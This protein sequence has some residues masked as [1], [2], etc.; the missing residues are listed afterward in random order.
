M[1]KR[2]NEFVSKTDIFTNYFS[3]RKKTS[4]FN[5]RSHEEFNYYEFMSMKLNFIQRRKKNKSLKN[6]Q[7][8]NRNS[9]KCY[10]CDK[11]NHFAKNCRSKRL[12]LQR[13]INATLKVVFETDK[14]WKKVV[15]SKYT[16]TSKDNSNDDYYLIDESKKLQQ[17]LN[18]IASNKI[19]V[20]TKE[21]NFNIKQIVKKRSRT[22]YSSAIYSKKIT[23]LK[24]IMNEIASLKKNQECNESNECIKNK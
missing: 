11:S 16:K 5:N 24:K 10:A 12:M 15:Y 1:K 3:E 7:Q 4:R 20:F 19:F 18:E 21:I 13:Q 23:S 17:V 8:N 9:K 2:Y 14:N 6:K 22:S